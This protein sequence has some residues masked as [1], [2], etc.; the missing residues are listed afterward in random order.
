M[1][2]SNLCLVFN[3]DDDMLAGRKYDFPPTSY[4]DWALNKLHD[5]M[6]SVVVRGSPG[7]GFRTYNEK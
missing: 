7:T 3:L 4:S 5:V 1:E 6:S 2:H